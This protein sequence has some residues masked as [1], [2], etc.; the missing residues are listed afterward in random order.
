[1][2][3]GQHNVLQ[4]RRHAARR[5][6]LLMLQHKC[7]ACLVLLTQE[8]CPS[9]TGAWRTTGVLN[10]LLDRNTKPGRT[11][12]Y[13]FIVHMGRSPRADQAWHFL[14]PYIGRT[15]FKHPPYLGGTWRP[16]FY[17]YNL[18]GHSPPITLP[19]L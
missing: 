17:S 1:M 8:A 19:S 2:K 12:Y 16:R 11:C 7:L 10:I 3:K 9:T 6:R 13:K 18:V 4:A 15:S 5:L 14:G